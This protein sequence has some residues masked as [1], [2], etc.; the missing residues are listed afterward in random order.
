M[1]VHTAQCMKLCMVLE[2]IHILF[3]NKQWKIQYG[4][5]HRLELQMDDFTAKL[6][7]HTND[8]REKEKRYTHIYC[9]LAAAIVWTAPVYM[10]AFTG[11]ICM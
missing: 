3:G 4:R 7:T 1:P 9:M 5:Q 8:G 6:N 11:P 10:S 2:W